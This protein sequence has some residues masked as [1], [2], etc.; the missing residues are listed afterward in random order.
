M[1]GAYSFKMPKS[2]YPVMKHHVPEEQNPQL[3]CCKE[4]MHRLILVFYDT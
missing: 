1:K 4:L 2:E 3:H